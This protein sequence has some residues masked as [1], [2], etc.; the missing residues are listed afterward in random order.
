M[1]SPE[2]FDT[3][4]GA[5]ARDPQYVDLR[6]YQLLSIHEVLVADRLN[7]DEEYED[8]TDRIIAT[9][10]VIGV[11]VGVAIWVTLWRS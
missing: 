5:M 10:T 1:I 8:T 6:V 7:D 4:L 2:H 11:I 9:L 3:E